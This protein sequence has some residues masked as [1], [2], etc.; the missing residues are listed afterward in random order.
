MD[1]GPGSKDETVVSEFAKIEK[2]LPGM[3]SEVMARQALEPKTLDLPKT[4]KAQ[5]EELCRRVAKA[6]CFDFDKGRMDM[7]D[8]PPWCPLSARIH[9][10][11]LIISRI[12]FWK[13]L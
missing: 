12:I 13:R 3:I 11:L 8:G 2:V 6:M 1:T 5:R 9:A 4:T 7:S 10:S